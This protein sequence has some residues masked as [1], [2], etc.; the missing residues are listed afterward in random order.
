[1]I[2]VFSRDLLTKTVPVTNTLKLWDD[3]YPS[4]NPLTQMKAAKQRVVNI[5]KVIKSDHVPRYS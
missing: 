4:G 1:M 2:L 5:Y 3:N